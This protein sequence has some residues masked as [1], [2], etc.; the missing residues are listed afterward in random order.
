MFLKKLRKK[1][2]QDARSGQA[3]TE[4]ALI[5]VMV[6]VL[7]GVTLAATGPAIGN[8]F[9]NAVYNLIGGR[10]EDV[11][12]LDDPSDGRGRSSAFWATVSW[13]ATNP[14]EERAGGLNTPLPPPPTATEGPTPTPS[15]ITPSPLPPDTATVPPTATPRD[16]QHVAPWLDRINNPEWW[17]VDNSVW[18]GTD[19]WIGDYYPNTAL[20][21]D[22]ALTLSHQ[23]LN[24]PPIEWQNIDFLWPNNTGPIESGF[25]TDNF[26]VSWTRQLYNDSPQPVEVQFTL[27][28]GG[29]NANSGGRLWLYE[30]DGGTAPADGC[31]SVAMGGSPN[32]NNDDVYGDGQSPAGSPTN[33]LVIDG[34]RNN[35][36]TFTVTRTLQPGTFYLVQ[37]DFYK[38]SGETS[39]SLDIAGTT[40]KN[41][42]DDTIPAGG[43]PECSWFRSDTVRSNSTSFIWEEARV[44]E[45]PQNQICYLE[46]RGWVNVLPL[47]NPQLIFWDVW[48]LG[49]TNTEVWLE[50][51]EYNADPASR[52][53]QQIP[54]NRGGTT[55]YAWTRNIVNLAPY[56]SGYQNVALRFAMRDT[57]GSSNRRWYVDDIELRDFGTQ[58]FGICTG[59]AL[60]DC[61]GTGYF[62]ME[63]TTAVFGNAA[64][65]IDPQFVTTGRWTLTSNN[66]R[67]VLA[68]DS[69]VPQVN[70]EGGDRIHAIEL[71]GLVDVTGSV[72]DFE[73]DDGAPV[74]TFNHAY[75]IEHGVRLEV[76][77]T[78]DTPD[79]TPDNWQVVETI[80]NNPLFSGT[81]MSQGGTVGTILLTGIPNF[82][83][84]PFRLRWAIY[85]NQFAGE[86][87]GW[88]ID[89]V[90]IHRFDA[91]R[92]SDYP[93]L[94]TAQGDLSNWL[95]EGTWGQ[96]GDTNHTP[97]LFAGSGRSFT[98]SP[99]GNYSSG[100]NSSL[101]LRNPI[102]LNNDTPENLSVDDTS[103]VQSGPATN[104]VL[105]FWHWRNIRSNHEIYLEW[106]NNRGLTW[107]VI[108]DFVPGWVNS[109][110]INNLNDQRAWEYVEVD[111]SDIQA[112]IATDGADLTDDDIIIRFRLDTRGSGTDEG[113]YIDDIRIEDR[114]ESSHKLWNPL[115]NDPTY[116]TGNGA[117][118]TDDID[119]GNYQERWIVGG[120][121]T[122][123][124]EEQH[125]GLL[126]LHESPPSSNGSTRNT[127]GNTYNVLELE[128]IID[129]RA[130]SASD[131]PALYFW[132]RYYLGDPPDNITIQIATENTGYSPTGGDGVRDTNNYERRAGWN[133]WATATWA[134]FSWS[135]VQTWQR[136]AVDLRNYAGERI[137]IRFVFNALD[138]GTNRDGWYID[139]LRIEHRNTTPFALSPFTDNARS[140][141]NWITEGSWGLAP[142]QWRG[143]GGGPADLGTNFWEGVYYDCEANFGGS[144]CWNN[145]DFNNLL[146]TDY[147]NGVQRPAGPND[148]LEFALEI[149]HDFGSTG[150]PAGAGNNDSWLDRYAARWTRDVTIS[151]AATVTFITVSDDGIRMRYDNVASPTAWNDWNIVE[152]WYP[153]GRWVDVEAVD[154]V[155]GNYRFTLEWFEAGGNAVV[156]VS[157][158]VN[159]FSFSD[160]PKAGNGPSFPVIESTSYGDSSMILRRPISLAGTTLPL[161]EYYTRYRL[162]G[163]NVG[164]VEVSTNGGF[165]WDTT[166]LNNWSG[167]GSSCP[168]GTACWVTV[169]GWHWP[170]D[171][172]QWQR[173]LH[174]LWHYMN[175]GYDLV[176]L[177]W[178][179]TTGSDVEDGWYVTDIAIYP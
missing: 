21:G 170:S 101:I 74:L 34:W 88:Q 67:D 50:V 46:L 57:G 7:F 76:Q 152:I 165:T 160:S 133:A 90:I 136:A 137:K 9:S 171:P 120:D 10:P 24:L 125:S 124:E 23:E 153:H 8:V 35:R 117:I 126:S 139:D 70:F 167:T 55:N 77:W 52:T 127:R 80:R 146:Y 81:T 22:P 6:A 162:G 25:V 53:W 161:I 177:R 154:F 106:S 75:S 99:L 78:R 144:G 13:L 92:F 4:Y 82:D 54:L 69:G 141:D 28:T 97:N 128:D 142:D 37:L 14:P 33:C 61:A 163:G 110:M 72:P 121:W 83:T 93:F 131:N 30:R 41:F 108:W 169:T 32:S 140:T 42:D 89:D 18:V 107:N 2:R 138:D 157:A 26:S 179:L 174:N 172:T 119:S 96:T 45:F 130:L 87:G 111:F 38:G 173:R 48:D 71:N 129:L 58:T 36:D 151:N 168:S 49:S 60:A 155:P 164:T 19:Q 158:G 11:E 116:G 62:D 43:V 95:A 64:Q 15:P 73:N 47:A 132:T 40:G 94:D 59:S 68:L 39:V 29:V 12:R 112:N 109:N 135:R 176:N 115:V 16:R 147:A 31:S 27:T 66:A 143:A 84:Q 91:P 123:I 122:D 102:D 98:D 145:N 134:R 51:G 104:P 5:L 17:R 148:I 178:R 114:T 3:L 86:S 156:I 113:I 175:Q 79:A 150:M 149:D 166:N 1:F 159:S 65:G 100:T 85:V 103:N 20:S 44:G 105:S 118:Y 56:V 63:N